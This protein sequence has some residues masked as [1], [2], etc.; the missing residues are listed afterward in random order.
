MNLRKREAIFKAQAPRLE[1]QLGPMHPDAICVRTNLAICV[2]WRG[3][4]LAANKT[5]L[6][7]YRLV[8]NYG[9]VPDG[10]GRLLWAACKAL[11]TV[12]FTANHS[13]VVTEQVVLEFRR[14][15]LNHLRVRLRMREQLKQTCKE[16]TACGLVVGL[17]A[18]MIT[19]DQH[20]S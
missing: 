3:N 17:L 5:F 12:G 20:V 14:E 16:V 8:P 10:P 1:E 19:L 6:E 13:V 7:L 2:A 11:E 4:L 15:L 9:A 18:G